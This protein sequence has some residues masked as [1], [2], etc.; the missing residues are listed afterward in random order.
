M[1]IL[2]SFILCEKGCIVL[3]ID[4]SNFKIDVLLLVNHLAT[5]VLF[6]PKHTILI[7]FWGANIFIIAVGNMFSKS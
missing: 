5:V 4:Y 3:K 7:L 6:R 2:G 1:T